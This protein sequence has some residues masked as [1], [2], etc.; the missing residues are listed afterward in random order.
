MSSWQSFVIGTLR[1]VAFAKVDHHV[2]CW[3]LAMG[4]Y[5]ATWD[6]MSC[7]AILWSLM[8][9]LFQMGGYCT[10]E[11]VSTVSLSWI[12]P[13]SSGC[14]LTF[15]PALHTRCFSL[16]NTGLWPCTIPS[17]DKSFEC[18]ILQ[19]YWIFESLTQPWSIAVGNGW[20]GETGMYGWD[21]SCLVLV[22]ISFSFILLSNLKTWLT[23]SLQEPG[24][25]RLVSVPDRVWRLHLSTLHMQWVPSHLPHL[26]SNSPVCFSRVL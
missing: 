5:N 1:F 14:K 3:S 8:R 19:G 23:D 24:S 25:I 21:W 4:I 12:W 18:R 2:I 11:C 6:S 26:T 22:S 20:Q 7:Q 16:S 17:N 9:E 10:I 13:P 15:V